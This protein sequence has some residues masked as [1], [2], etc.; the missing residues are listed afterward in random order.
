M[1]DRSATPTRRR[2]HLV[3]WGA[4]T[5][6]A[7]V[8]AVPLSQSAVAGT[9]GSANATT[10]SVN[11]NSNVEPIDL[12]L[13]GSS[14]QVSAPPGIG[15]NTDN[16]DVSIEYLDSA[17][18][19]DVIDTEAFRYDGGL[20]SDS[21]TS[22]ASL[23]LL[24]ELMF[25][26]GQIGATVLCPTDD[27]PA[28]GGDASAADVDLGGGP[29]SLEAGE[30]TSYSFSFDS[31][32]FDPNTASVDLS[33]ETGVSQGNGPNAAIGLQVEVSVNG[34][35]LGVGGDPVEGIITGTVVIAEVDCVP[36]GLANTG[37][38]STGI[39]LLAAVMFLAA[40]SS[41]VLWTRRR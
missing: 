27:E 17:L 24:G 29:V 5:A 18:V 6:A 30:S 40:G 26:S 10:A 3:G 21:N 35:P 19:V 28:G 9:G 32:Y 13:Q 23:T 4:V 36:E 15:T 34:T 16:S 8:V 33:A 14:E 31:P 20:S 41:A 11:I 12:N 38:E 22:S 7:V 37:P 2:R 25:T 39:L 1:R